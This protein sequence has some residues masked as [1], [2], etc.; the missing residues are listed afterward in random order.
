[1]TIDQLNSHDFMT[2]KHLC[3]FLFGLFTLGAPITRAADPAATSDHDVVIYGGTSAGIIAGIQALKMGKSVV[4]I[5]PSDCEGGLTTGGL[6]QT[7]IGN[8]MVIGG[9]SRDFYRRIARYYSEPEVWKWQQRE[10]FRDGGQTRTGKGEQTMWTF[11]PSAALTVYRN[12]IA[13]VG[14][15]LILRERLDR[16][17][18]VKMKS[19]GRFSRGRCSSTALMKAT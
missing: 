9:L 2:Y 17:D 7:D 10:D 16:E 13:E 3:L 8:K 4:V 12:W 1:M 15:A 5:E 6:G 19:P 11:E 18:G 14:L